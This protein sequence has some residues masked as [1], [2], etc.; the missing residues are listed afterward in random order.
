[1]DDTQFRICSFIY[2]QT[3]MK[4]VQPFSLCSG[5]KMGWFWG[6]WA[7]IECHLEWQK[8]KVS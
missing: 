6:S 4:S 1:M 8:T 7:K 5:H 3:E 2:L